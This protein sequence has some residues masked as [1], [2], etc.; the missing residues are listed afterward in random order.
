[1]AL[2]VAPGRTQRRI[3]RLRERITELQEQLDEGVGHP[4]RTVEALD[5]FKRG[6]FTF[7]EMELAIL[8]SLPYEGPW[9]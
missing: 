5:D 6:I 8:D 2:T 7:E 1:M 9:M 3:A 4:E